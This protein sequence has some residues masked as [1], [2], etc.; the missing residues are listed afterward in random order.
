M[1]MPSPHQSWESESMWSTLPHHAVMHIEARGHHASDRLLA[2]DESCSTM[3][4]SS[5]RPL[6]LPSGEPYYELHI[7]SDKLEDWVCFKYFNATGESLVRVSI[8]QAPAFWLDFES[9]DFDAAT[10]LGLPVPGKMRKIEHVAESAWCQMC[11]SG[12]SIKNPLCTDDGCGVSFTETVV[13][14]FQHIS[15]S[16]A[17]VAK[18]S[19]SVDMCIASLQDPV[20][21]LTQDDIMIYIKSGILH[22]LPSNRQC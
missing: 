20:D 11:T 21:Q 7:F 19:R 3:I 10:G 4:G 22:M 1:A 9:T 18:Q 17:F 6:T 2:F 8:E 13:R 5:F 15:S 14:L 16:D 12:R